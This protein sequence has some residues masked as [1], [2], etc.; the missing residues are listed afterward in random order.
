M[1]VTATKLYFKNKAE[2]GKAYQKNGSLDS[3]AKFY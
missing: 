3:E 2:V 1:L